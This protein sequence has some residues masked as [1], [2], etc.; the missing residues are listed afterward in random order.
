L[1]LRG[2]FCGSLAHADPAAEWCLVAATLNVELVALSIRGERRLTAR[3]FFRGAMATT[4]A[5]DELLVEA[6]LPILPDGTRFG[7]A[8]FSR[9]AG[10]YALAIA[11][12]VLS[13]DGGIIAAARIALRGAAATPRRSEHDDAG[14]AG[15]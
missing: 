10:D 15:C 5:P 14:T 11:L 2:T 3:D 13:I 9:R 8:E 4:L 12:V 7:F 6:R 1:R